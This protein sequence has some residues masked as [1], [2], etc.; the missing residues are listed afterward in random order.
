M[1]QT[2]E[3]KARFMDCPAYREPWKVD[4]EKKLEALIYWKMSLF[5]DKILGEAKNAMLYDS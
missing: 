1:L 3:F 2:H 4:V 5:V